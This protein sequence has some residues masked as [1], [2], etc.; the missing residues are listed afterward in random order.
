M[1][2][3]RSAFLPFIRTILVGQARFLPGMDRIVSQYQHEAEEHVTRLRQ[4]EL[5]LLFLTLLTLLL[6][7]LFIFR[8]AV[9][10][11]QQTFADL[12]QAHERVA[13]EE[14]TRKKAERILALN[15][16]L[17]ASQ[18][19]SP[20]A[21][22]VAFGHYQVRGKEGIYYN[23]YQ[24]AI[25]GQQVFACECLQYQEHMICPHSLTASALHRISGLQ[26][27]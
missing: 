2:T 17:T 26:P 10:R 24:H 15:E 23:V 13:R 20:H 19:D 5:T 8:P 12:L 6:E 3:Q 21:R 7:G 22:I 16:A 27:H 14:V 4:I 18:R 9:R 25:D 11:L 1:E